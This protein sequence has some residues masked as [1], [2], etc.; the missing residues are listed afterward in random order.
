[1][2]PRREFLKTAAGLV[3]GRAAQM[4]PARKPNVLFLLASQLRAPALE[5]DG[6]SDL[7]T[8][9][10]ELLARQGTWFD[11]L[12]ASCPV[13]SPSRAALITGRYPFASGVTRAA[14]PLPVAQ[15][16]IA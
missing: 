5:M 15:P 7:R 16:S 1:M 6:D 14:V 12:Y 13:A 9:N 4:A 3:A 10:L 2:W 8:P 11:R